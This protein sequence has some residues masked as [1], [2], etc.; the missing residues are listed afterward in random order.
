MGTGHRGEIPFDLSQSARS[1]GTGG[2]GKPPAPSSPPGLGKGSGGKP[3][4]S[5]LS[6]SICDDA[7]RQ[8]DRSGIATDEELGGTKVLSRVDTEKSKWLAT[9]L[10]HRAKAAGVPYRKDGFMKVVDVFQRYVYEFR[11]TRGYRPFDCQQLA[12]IVANSEKGRFSVWLEKGIM[13]WI[14][15]NQGHSLPDLDDT[16]LF[17]G[18]ISLDDLDEGR[19]CYHGTKLAYV[20][21]IIK[22]GIHAGGIAAGS[23]SLKGK[24]KGKQHQQGRAHIHMSPFRPGDPRQKAGM[25]HESEAIVVVDAKWAMA[26]G[27]TIHKGSARALLC[28]DPIPHR[29]LSKVFKAE[30]GSLIYDRNRDTWEIS[31]RETARASAAADP[32]TGPTLLLLGEKGP[33]AQKGSGGK[34][35][36]EGEPERLVDCVKCKLWMSSLDLICINC[37][38]NQAN[39]NE[40]QDD[41]PY[42]LAITQARA[43][44][45][46][47]HFRR[48]LRNTGFVCRGRSSI[49]TLQADERRTWTKRNK[50]AGELHHYADG[51]RQPHT[52]RFDNDPWYRS[53][54]IRHGIP[55]LVPLL[56]ARGEARPFVA[57]EQQ[58]A[59]GKLGKG[60]SG[61][62]SPAESPREGK[63]G[64]GGGGKG[65]SRGKPQASQ[66][67]S[68]GWHGGAGWQ[69][70]K[71]W[72][73]GAGWQQGGGWYGGAGQQQQQG[74]G[75][76]PWPQEPP[77]YQGGGWGSG[78]GSSGGSGGKTGK[79]GKGHK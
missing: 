76:G 60:R 3:Q 15:A 68:K 35:P 19:W 38:E 32:S 45:Y 59:M 41:D 49:R 40:A 6:R 79:G 36:A 65:D 5:L 33:I 72:H 51:D 47:D 56:A 34:P 21:S 10:R 52:V 4:A 20:E 53:E 55:R 43:D 16:E 77:S 11:N 17:S 31:R 39:R 50:R 1:G 71:G 7:A 23:R 75:Q 54:M 27:I 67:Q 46:H 58:I 29:F 62:K 64:R 61:G 42:T 8:T 28:R 9:L 13:S 24:S 63:K 22:E 73:G 70:G 2:G 48:L 26:E 44:W 57:T 12:R 14:R 74:W 30:D 37:G 25:R 69:Q 66:P 78:P 18:P